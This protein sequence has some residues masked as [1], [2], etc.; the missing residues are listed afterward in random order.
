MKKKLILKNST[1][2][3]NLNYPG[4]FHVIKLWPGCP[5]LHQATYSGSTL[6]KKLVLEQNTCEMPINEVVSWA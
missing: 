3:L 5:G 6:K 2:K 4:A 1:R